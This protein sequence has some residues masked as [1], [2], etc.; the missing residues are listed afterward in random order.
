MQSSGAGDSF[1]VEVISVAAAC[2][3]IGLKEQNAT[4]IGQVAQ[5]CPQESLVAVKTWFGGSTRMIVRY[6]R[7]MV[8]RTFSL[9]TVVWE[10]RSMSVGKPRSSRSG[11]LSFDTQYP[12]NTQPCYL[13]PPLT[14]VT[15]SAF[16]PS[17]H[18]KKLRKQRNQAY[19]EGLADDSPSIVSSRRRPSSNDGGS[20]MENQDDQK[21]QRQPPS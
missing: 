11:Y 17:T 16:Y 9:S 10:L 20:W 21:I 6:I 12:S 14:A 19:C 5:E 13:S 3:S 4:L 18:N 7:I 1:K 15:L 8:V 2:V